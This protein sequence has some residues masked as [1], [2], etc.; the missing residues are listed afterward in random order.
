MGNML[1]YLNGNDFAD[2]LE[3]LVFLQE[4]EIITINEKVM[5]EFLRGRY[6]KLSKAI[7]KWSDVKN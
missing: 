1:E 4:E 7:D 5:A 2:V 3:F 6:K